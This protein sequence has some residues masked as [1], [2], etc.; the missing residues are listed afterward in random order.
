MPDL[1]EKKNRPTGRPKAWG[2]V[3]VHRVTGVATSRIAVGLIEE[4]EMSASRSMARIGNVSA[5]F[6]R[7]AKRRRPLC[8]RSS[9][10]I[11]FRK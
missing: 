11:F 7:D 1:K 9:T 5:I 3:L 4:N 6:R 2:D 10:F 8:C